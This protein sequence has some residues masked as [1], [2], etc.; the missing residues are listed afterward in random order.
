MSVGF[1]ILA[2]QHLHRVAQIARYW[3]THDCPVVIHVDARAPE[4]AF[5]DLQARL[6]ALK[7]VRFVRR[8]PCEWGRF[9]IVAATLD[10]AETMLADF[11]DVGHVFLASGAC[12][13]IRPAAELRDFLARHPQ[14][15]FIQSVTTEEV[16][17][18]V[19]GLDLERFTLFFPF[20]WKRQRRLFDRFVDLQRR[21][22][23]ARRIPEGIEPHLGSQWWCLTRST[24]QA[25]LAD[26]QR[27]EYDRY[28]R[29]VWIPDESYF[30]SLVRKHSTHVESRSLTLARFDNQGKPYTFYDD[31]LPLLQR[32]DCFVARKIWHGADLLYDRFLADG[33][34]P[35]AHPQPSPR[36]LDKVFARARARREKGRPGLAMQSRFAR[37]E[38]E[39][40]VNRTAAPYTVLQGFAELF[41]NF[42][43]WLEKRTGL[44]VHGHLFDKR[45]AEFAGGATLFDGCLSDSARLRDHDP[46]A[47]LRNLVWNTRGERQC[48]MF[49]PADRQE[50]TDFIA[51]D[52]NAGVLVITG[53]WAVPLFHSRMNFRR[54]RRTAARFQAREAAFLEKLNDLHHRARVHVWSLA[55]FVD[56]PIPVLKTLLAELDAESGNRLTAVPRLADLTGFGRFVQRLRNEGMD[57]YLLADFPADEPAE[58]DGDLPPAA[59]EAGRP[60]AV[61]EG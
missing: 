31:H 4:E 42:Q 10:A 14:T 46:A 8:R 50:I 44:R 13:P 15:D 49:G 26:P 60:Y 23:Y 41:E 51:S 39:W 32:S 17:W 33:P 52:A 30:Q 38:V 19:G 58:P 21:I 25:I 47:F 57:P 11:P 6:S 9:S 22:G 55:E 18:T 29:H 59:I 45:R 2:H 53:A 40:N 43:P 28:F 54:I 24:L 35:V 27:A 16:S 48:F 36:N 3:A 5:R 12:L 34:R 1:I 56:N 7:L 37:A 20:S 61:G